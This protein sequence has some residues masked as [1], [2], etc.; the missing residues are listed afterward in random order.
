MA[1]VND[2]LVSARAN[3]AA[4]ARDRLGWIPALQLKQ[5]N[6]GNAPG[7][8]FPVPARQVRLHDNLLVRIMPARAYVS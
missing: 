2:R 6:S 4:M 8:D 1:K 7:G 5:A 3:E